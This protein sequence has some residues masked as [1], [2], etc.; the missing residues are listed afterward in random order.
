MFQYLFLDILIAK[1]LGFNN[2]IINNAENQL[3]QYKSTIEMNVEELNKLI[4]E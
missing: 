1:K 2:E 4:A 3:I